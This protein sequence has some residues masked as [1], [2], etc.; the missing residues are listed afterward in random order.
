MKKLLYIT[1]QEEYS[2]HGTIGPL[3]HGYLKEYLHV[4]VVYYTKY[5]HSFQVKGDDFVVPVQHDKDIIEYLEK[6]QVDIS[7]YDYVFVRN[8]KYILK[9]VIAYQDKYRYK[10]GFRASFAKS[11]QAYERTKKGNRGILKALRVKIGNMSKNRLVNKVDIFMPA[12]VQ[13]QKVFYPNITCK[14][15]PLVTA[16]DPGSISTRSIRD[17]GVRRFIYVGSLDRL[18]EFEV[19]L[20]AF[21]AIKNLSW[22]LSVVVPNP[23]VI[24]ELLKVYPAIKNKVDIV[25]ADELDEIKAQVCGSDVGLALLPDRELYNNALSAKVAD[26]YSCSVPALLSDNEKNR[27]IFD[28]KSEALF[29]AF[30]SNE[31]SEKLK[32]LIETPESELITIGQKGQQKLLDLGRNYKDMAKNLYE[33]LET[34]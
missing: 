8:I 21:Y 22:S 26:Y 34:L 4:N 11:T 30:E 15:Y 25:N 10:V 5:K 29:S 9:T 13:M 17:D 6:K 27:S 28:E 12:S 24:I 32:N 2:E 19:V 20:D 23:E 31:I 33:E 1:D 14:V 7:Q 16:L 3:F 18:R